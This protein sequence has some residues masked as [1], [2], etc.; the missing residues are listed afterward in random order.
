M[1][2]RIGVQER[3]KERRRRTLVRG[4]RKRSQ[5]SG[6]SSRVWR[7]PVFSARE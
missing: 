7:K 4:G 2:R 1:E 5:Q 3:R 6:V